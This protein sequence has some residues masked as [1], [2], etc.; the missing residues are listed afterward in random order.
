[1]LDVGG[2]EKDVL[3]LAVIGSEVSGR[4]SCLVLGDCG[5]TKEEC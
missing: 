5:G 2:K 4:W 3:F 1:M